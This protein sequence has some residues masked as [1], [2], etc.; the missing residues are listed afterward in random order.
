MK[1]FKL[2]YI[3]LI[4]LASCSLTKHIPHG[5]TL[6]RKD[7]LKI[8]GSKENLD[9]EVVYDVIKQ[10]PNSK[11]F[12][13]RFKLRIYN[14]IDSSKVANKRLRLNN[15][16]RLINKKRFLKEQRINAKR[17]KK[18]KAKGEEFY[19]RKLI[20]LKDTIK[21]ALY[22]LTGDTRVVRTGIIV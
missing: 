1:F 9:E 10:H 5:T 16:L 22:S 3:L 6:I 15:R 4:F 14:W 21:A 2:T 11:I 8:V 12:G 19:T 13:I 18:A 7:K 17:I 20:P